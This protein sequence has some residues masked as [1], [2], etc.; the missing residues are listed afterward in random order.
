MSALTVLHVTSEVA[1][2]SKTGG[3]GDVVASLPR[4]LARAGVRVQVV[5]P[6]YREIDPGRHVLA[7]RLT[8][9][10][11]PLGPD[12]VVEVGLYEGTLPGGVVPVTFLDHPL[13]DR[14]GYY[15]E[16]GQDYPDNG[17]RFG[18]LCRAALELCHRSGR[19]PDL[20]H[21]HDWQAGLAVLMAA[22]GVVPGR[23]IPKTVF[24]IHN[25]AFQGLV[26]PSLV[27]ELG[28]PG[29]VFNPEGLEFYGKASLLKAGLAFADRITTVSPRY[30]REI[31]TGELGGGLDGFLRER[32]SRI[33]GILNGIDPDVWSPERDPMIPA[34][35]DSLDR[36][37]KATCKA[38]LQ[39]EVGLAVRSGVP[40]V[41]SISRLTEQK[42][43]DLIAK[44]HDDLGRMDAQFVFLGT[45]EPRYQAALQELARRYPAKVAL[46]IAYDEALA[47]R[48]EAGS[49][50]FL[51][52]SRFEPCGL[53]QL[54]SLRYGT[55]PVVRA[56]GG[57]DDTIV[58][59]DDQSTTGTGFKIAEYSPDALVRTLRRA[60]A[61]YQRKREWHELVGRIMTLDFSW[62]R[63]ARLYREL[64]EK[65]VPAAPAATQQPAA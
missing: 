31:Q 64:Y 13:Y 11:V 51:M 28:L 9:L 59:Y 5:T 41:G 37:G 49:D 10:S 25:L 22:R 27:T 35:Y 24:T 3:L 63:S 21:A 45:G 44:A 38:A 32:A 20:V 29:D 34:R 50:F 60:L 39:R 8:P 62:N 48:I 7:R 56:V 58:D 17:L 18:L 19:W 65:L 47:H 40:L 16:G 55:V 43:F 12:R 15:G 6:R 23:P 36:T 1:P 42:G 54:Y 14:D 33:V 26:D 52:P 57:L 2:F 53:N 4:A 46:R 61:T 30:A